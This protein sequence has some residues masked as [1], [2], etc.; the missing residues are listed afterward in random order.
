VHC[1]ND[2]G[3]TAHDLYIAVV[4]DKGCIIPICRLRKEG[5]G[6]TA[7]DVYIAG[8]KRMD[9]LRAMRTLAG[10]AT[11]NVLCTMYANSSKMRRDRTRRRDSEDKK[12][13]G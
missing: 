11:M 5:Y 6:C 3:D 8:S 12:T 10:K 7:Q 2:K 4:D 1:K 13:R 9:V